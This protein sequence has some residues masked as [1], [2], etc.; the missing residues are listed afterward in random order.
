[1]SLHSLVPGCSCSTCRVHLSEVCAWTS[2]LSPAVPLLNK[3]GSVPPSPLPCELNTAITCRD[4]VAPSP[5]LPR[6][7]T[8]PPPGPPHK[9]GSQGDGR[10]RK[11]RRTTSTRLADGAGSTIVTTTVAQPSK[12]QTPLV[13]G[14][15]A[16]R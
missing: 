11:R 5:I 16:A 15:K 9:P 14:A 3:G 8:H 2:V 12:F 13:G 4:D 7:H 1:M 6:R 10:Q